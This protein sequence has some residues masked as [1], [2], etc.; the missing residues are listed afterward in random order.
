[1]ESLENKIELL[2][3]KIVVVLKFENKLM[4]RFSRII[5]DK[6]TFGKAKKYIFNCTY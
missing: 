1:M 6:D 5:N 4:L 3:L 2:E